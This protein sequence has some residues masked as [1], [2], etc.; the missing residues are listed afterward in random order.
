MQI[1]PLR[2][3]HALAYRQLMLYGYEHSPE[4]F[5]TTP[6]ECAEVPASWWEK[7]IADPEGAGLAFGAFVG[8]Q[9]CGAV[10]LLFSSRPKTRH[11]AHV[12]GVYVQEAWRAR[13]LGRRLMHA[14]LQHV[15]Q[16]SGIKA[17]LLSVAERNRSAIALYESLGFHSFGIE[18]MA[19]STGQGYQSMV[20]MYKSIQDPELHS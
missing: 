7:R 9:L 4:A 11:K 18:P 15:E 1:I 16:R 10:T 12:I 5:L 14:A 3:E 2:V 20:H 13:G 19:F 17:L 6:E 8:G